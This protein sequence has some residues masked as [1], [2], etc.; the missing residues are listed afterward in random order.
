VSNPPD[1]PSW[2]RMEHMRRGGPLLCPLNLHVSEKGEN[3]MASL[4][5]G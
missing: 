1:I 4:V 2:K 3:N 5:R